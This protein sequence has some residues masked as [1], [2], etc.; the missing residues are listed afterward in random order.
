MSNTAPNR[1]IRPDDPLGKLVSATLDAAG[2]TDQLMRGGDGAAV[3]AGDTL[4]RPAFSDLYT[5][6]VGGQLAEDR[7]RGIEAWLARDSGLAADLQRLLENTSRFRFPEVAAA[8]SGE[9][10]RREIDG[11]RLVF[12]E[13]KANQSHLFV[14]LELDDRSTEVPNHLFL[15]YPDKSCERV[16]LPG[17]QSG[18]VQ[19]LLEDQ[20]RLALGLR[21]IRTEIYLR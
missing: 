21:D 2:L 14:V 5:Y 18:R 8:S 3:V 7:Q 12:K 10:E 15:C 4:P 13:S 11:A 16:S 1:K 19:L 20:S 9:I 17:A 6:A